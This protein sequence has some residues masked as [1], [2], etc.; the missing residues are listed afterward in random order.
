M[1]PKIIHYCWLSKDPLPTEAQECIKSWKKHMPDWQIKLWDMDAFDVHSVPFVEEAVAARKWAFACDYIRVYALYT[2]GGVYLDSDVLVRKNMDF[3]LN[4]HAFSAIE[5]YPQ[6]L[7]TLAREDRIDENGIKRNPEDKI[8]G[9]QIQAAV[10]GAEKG[11]PFFKDCL[12]YYNQRHFTLEKD[13]IPRED[14]ISPIVFAGI[15][16]KYGFRYLNQ[17]QLLDEDFKLYSTDI[18]CPQ[19]YLMRPSAVAVHCCNASWRTVDKPLRHFFENIKTYLK[20]GLI[21]IGLRKEKNI[22]RLR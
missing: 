15:A 1:I 22:E 5:S 4:N 10:L 20:Q 9:I 3:M 16:E 18:I 11:H 21:G 7:E 17:E 8:H 6:L 19:P 2:E 14:Q 12:D 13:G